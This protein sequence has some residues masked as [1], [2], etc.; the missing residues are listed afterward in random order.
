[1]YLTAHCG[2]EEGSG[3]GAVLLMWNSK[4]HKENALAIKFPCWQNTRNLW[5]PHVPFP[6]SLCESFPSH[7]TG[8]LA[9]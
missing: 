2:L 8:D 9:C 3:S 6:Q 1:M 5:L 4:G 7:L